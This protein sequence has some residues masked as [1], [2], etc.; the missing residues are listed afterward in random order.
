MAKF[1][2]AYPVN[3]FVVTQPFGI[4]REYYR[5]HGINILGHNGHD[6]QAYHGQP[7]YAAHDGIAYYEIDAS[8]GEGVV[9]RTTDTFDYKGQS[10]FFKSLYWHMIDTL[11]EPKYKQIIPRSGAPVSVKRGDLIGFADNTGF[12]TGDHVH[13]AIK[14]IVYGQQPDYGDGSDIGIGNFINLEPNNG[15]LGAI[16]A[17]P[18]WAGYYATDEQKVNAIKQ[19]IAKLKQ[20]IQD[21]IW[22]IMRSK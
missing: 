4:N 17:T 22:E 15:Y 13:F 6:L 12:S 18:Y 10:V 16:D 3:P 8:Q 20:A 14:P 2:I 5:T 9:I 7:V 19:G 21:Y 1:E 11:K